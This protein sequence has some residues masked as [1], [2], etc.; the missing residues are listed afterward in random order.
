MTHNPLPAPQTKA[1]IAVQLR[2]LAEHMLDIAVSMEHFGAAAPWATHGR[3]LA[4][5][6]ELCIE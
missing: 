5:A 1:E 6:A 4:G 3:E 2:W